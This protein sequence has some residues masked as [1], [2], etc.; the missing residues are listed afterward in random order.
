MKF[1]LFSGFALVAS[2]TCS[3]IQYGMNNDGTN[4]GQVMA[5]SSADCCNQC[6]STLGCVGWTYVTS[7]GECWL[8]SAV[9]GTRSDST[10]DSGS[11]TSN[12]VP[13]PAPSPT[14]NG[15]CPGGSLEA[16]VHQCPSDTF[17]VCVSSCQDCCVN[18]NCGSA[19]CGNNDGSD[20][21]TCV[22]NCP[23]EGFADCVNCCQNKFAP[24]PSPPPPTACGDDDGDDLSHCVSNCPS[25]TFAVCI[26]CCQ[27]KFPD[28]PT[29]S[30]APVPTTTKTTTTTTTTTA[31]CGDKDGNDLATCV[32][33][34]PSATFAACITCCQGKFP[35]ELVLV[36]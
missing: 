1:L 6:S 34:C 8:K 24:S 28:A 27:K 17:G 25:D 26:D 16:C 18:G 33:N 22:T 19:P 35:E 23:S 20:L 5:S 10:V 29:P 31:P 9:G 12:S 21:S 30:P 11:V 7:S 36:A 4:L 15:Q 14:F 13:T 3:D 32:G 2:Q